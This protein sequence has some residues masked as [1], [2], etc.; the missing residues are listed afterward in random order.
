[1]ATSG[2][3]RLPLA[4]WPQGCLF[5]SECS[6]AHWVASQ[7]CLGVMVQAQ[8]WCHLTLLYRLY[9]WRLFHHAREPPAHWENLPLKISRMIPCILPYPGMSTLQPERGLYKNMESSL[10]AQGIIQGVDR[11]WGDSTKLWD[12]LS[13]E[14]YKGN[15]TALQF[16]SESQMLCGERLILAFV[17]SI[18]FWPIL[19]EN[20]V[21]INYI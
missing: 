3:W 16:P 12:F 17:F 2:R 6:L 13:K 15:E 9:M 8:S 20:T 11:D 21:K 4:P 18:H 5:L 7:G 14:I 1:M 19:V 10:R